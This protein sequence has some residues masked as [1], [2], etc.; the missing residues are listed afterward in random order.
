[1]Q[2][3][4]VKSHLILFFIMCI[5]PLAMQYVPWRATETHL[6]R[7]PC[8]NKT[9]TLRSS[10]IN[11]LLYN[12]E[13]NLLWGLKGY[14]EIKVFLILTTWQDHLWYGLGKRFVDRKKHSNISL[15][16][17]TFWL[18]WKQEKELLPIWEEIKRTEMSIHTPTDIHTVRCVREAVGN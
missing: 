10:I 8:S 18:V 17:F 14:D 16:S 3:V 1:M 11:K 12:K 6:N 15:L 5:W 4:G 9:P 2:L 13:D 7:G